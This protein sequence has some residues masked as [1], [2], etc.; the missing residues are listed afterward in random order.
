MT[1][2]C[3]M[4]EDVFNNDEIGAGGG[5]TKYTLQNTPEEKPKAVV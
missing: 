5:L 2:H 1:T 3:R 4:G